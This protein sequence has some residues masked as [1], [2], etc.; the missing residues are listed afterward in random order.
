MPPR[1]L[2][3][4]SK[5]GTWDY[6][7]LEY[8]TFKG[9]YPI[10]GT[11]TIP[12]KLVI[13]NSN[14]YKSITEGCTI[15]MFQDD[16]IIERFWNNPMAYIERFEVAGAVMSP[17]YSLLVGMPKPMQ[18]W[19][20]YRNRLVGHIWETKGIN[21]VPTIGWSDSDSFEYCFEGVEKES[22]ITVS[23]IGCRN[24]D[25]K[26]Y[27]DAG[28]NA[29]IK[30]I[31]PKKIVFMCNNK[32]KSYYEGDDRIIFIKPRIITTTKIK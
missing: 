7:K 21:V 13:V 24:D 3:W 27:F 29:M 10:I 22:I 28:F 1:N 16:Y 32:Y 5:S 12:D 25:N 14:D 26:S 9:D 31:N 20:V 18:M 17:D 8:V 2:N 15:T 23:N 30:A 11:S 19:Q 6:P 4:N